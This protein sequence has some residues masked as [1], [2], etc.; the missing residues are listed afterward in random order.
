MITLLVLLHNI[1]NATAFPFA[2]PL[3]T[4]LRATGDVGFTTVISIFTM[5]GVRLVF[6][7][8]FGIALRQG[9]LGIAWAMC[10]DWVIRGIIFSSAFLG[11]NGKIFE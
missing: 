4:G 3:G 11:E 9:V 2:D 7:L 6:S 5:V 1:F 10:L 8:L